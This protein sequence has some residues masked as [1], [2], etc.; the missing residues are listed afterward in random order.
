MQVQFT[1]RHMDLTESLKSYTVAKV[2]KLTRYLDMI[3]DAQ[4]TLS[5][6][7]Y[8][9]CA[10]VLIKTSKAAIKGSEVSDDMYLSIDRVFDKLEKQI[11]RQKDRRLARRPRDAAFKETVPEG[12]VS[13]QDDA[14]DAKDI[15]KEEVYSTIVKTD[16]VQPKPMSV[17]EAM[18]QFKMSDDSFF[19]FRDAHEDRCISILYRMNDGKM[20]LLQAR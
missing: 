14:I 10:E 3:Q 4:V 12:S 8:R 2:E 6:E 9:H 15:V 13:G 18:M 17:E 7:K 11:R 5:I 1:A 20:G 19:A 16:I